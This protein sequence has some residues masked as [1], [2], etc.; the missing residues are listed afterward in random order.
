[1]SRQEATLRELRAENTELRTWIAMFFCQDDLAKTESGWK[2][3][4][5]QIGW[6]DA[7][8]WLVNAVMAAEAAGEAKG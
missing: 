5:P 6:V 2:V 3:D 4:N 7:P 1:M 8:D